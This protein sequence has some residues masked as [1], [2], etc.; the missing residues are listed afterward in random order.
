MQEKLAEV[1]E[2]AKVIPV[3]VIDDVE[4]ALPLAEALVEGGLNVLEITLRTEAALAAVERIAKQLPD[5]HIGTGTVLSGEDVRRSEDAGA[6]FM[7]SPGTTEQLLDAAESSDVPLLPGV[8]NPSEVMRLLERGYRYQKFFPAQAAGGVPM[9]KS[10]GGP[11]AQV[12]F[13]PT[14]GVSPNN[15]RDYLALP[16]VICV[17]GSWMAAVNLVREKRWAEITR[18]AKEAATL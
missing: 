7:V 17:G 16:N 8:A 10:I 15:A 5:A 14:G 11:L 6:S 3:L 18:L 13:C 2:Q 9:L 12:R 1:L 4:D